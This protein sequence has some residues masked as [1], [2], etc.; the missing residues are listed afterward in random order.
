MPHTSSSPRLFCLNIHQSVVR[1]RPRRQ[2]S[3]LRSLRVTLSNQLPDNQ[4]LLEEP[5]LPILQVLQLFLVQVLQVIQRPLEVFGKHIQVKALE[6]QP[7]RCVSS[8]KV[9]VWTAL[10]YR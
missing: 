2:F 4:V 5:L 1:K 7:A 3:R 10:Y 8:S 9:F 6:S